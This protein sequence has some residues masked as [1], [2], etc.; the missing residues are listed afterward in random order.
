MTEPVNDPAESTGAIERGALPRV[1]KPSAGLSTTA[2][3]IGAVVAAIIL[4]SILDARRRSLAAP[5]VRPA[6]ADLAAVSDAPPPLYI[7]PSL[8]P[9]MAVPILPVPGI[10]PTP[11]V[12]EVRPI[13]ASPPSSPVPLGPPPISYAPPPPVA[14]PRTVSGAILVMD[15]SQPASGDRASAASGGELS[16]AGSDIAGR[17]RAGAMSDR[18]TTVPQ[19]TLI[20]AVLETAFNSTGSGF[21]RAL[22]QRDVYGF[23]GTRVLIPRGSRLIGEYKSETAQG[24]KRAFVTWTRLIRPD[25]VTIAI[26]SPTTDP[27]G[28]G[29]IRAK[30]DSHFFERFAGSILQTAMLI[31]GNLAARSVG[32]SVVVALPGS[33]PG[34]ATSTPATQIPPT[35]SVRQGTSISVFVARDLDFTTVEVRR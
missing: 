11:R 35:L 32:D 25:G 12:P 22:V 28:V 4:F 16:S 15:N 21:A 13:P 20:P 23:D 6:R 10:A 29:G 3:V 5:A 27:V 9:A 1:A 33:F 7:P 8:P 14:P 18:A 19:G 31:G 26:G 34:A 17:S 2:I 30:V 24:Q